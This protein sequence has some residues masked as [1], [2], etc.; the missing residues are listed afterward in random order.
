M[1]RKIQLPV[2][3]PRSFLELLGR[4]VVGN[5]AVAD[6]GYV[7]DLLLLRLLLL[8]AVLRAVPM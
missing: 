7:V 6:L 4:D 8:V 5:P 1:H 2:P 3:W